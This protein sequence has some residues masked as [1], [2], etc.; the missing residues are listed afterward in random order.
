M[1]AVEFKNKIRSQEE[2]ATLL[3]PRPRAKKAI[4]CHGTFDIVHPGHLRHLM[5]AKEKADVLIASITADEFIAKGAYR[6]YVPQDLRAANLAALELVDFV[7]VDHNATPIESIRKIQP[8]YFAKGY[9]YVDGGVHPKTQEEIKALDSYGGEMVFT[10][11]DIVYSSSAL[12]NL[13]APSL[14]V[15]KLLALMESEKVDFGDLRRVLHQM[16]GVPVHVVGDTIVDGYSYC[17]LLGT[18]PKHPTFSVHYERTDKYAGAA[19]IV[20]RHVKAAGGN[21][22]FSTLL[23]DDEHGRFTQKEMESSGIKCL[24]IVDSTRPT[25]YKE[26]FITDGHRLLQVDR[27]DNRPISEKHLKVFCDSLRNVEAAVVLFSDFR[28]GIFNRHTV[29]MLVPAIP[30]SALKAADSQVSNRWGNILDFAEFDLITPNEREARFALGDQDLV[31]RPMALE[32]YRRA[33]CKNLILK[34]GDRGLITYRSAGPNPRQFFTLDSLVTTLVD[35]VGAGDALLAYASLALAVSQSIVIASILG[36]MAAAA[37]CEREGNIPVTPHDV[38]Q[39]IS[40]IEKRVHYA[41]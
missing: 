15:E 37:A 10:P 33:R 16:D 12:I 5:Y 31:V 35:P 24:P 7:F 6:P 27:M 20:S 41:S 26:R 40:H 38:E 28:H 32:L 17:S 22:T 34:L 13:K 23:G 25:T 30:P 39:A 2:I 11:G 21:V 8:D 9:E 14:S 4:M 19:A 36:A 29:P 1:A 3:G 18:S